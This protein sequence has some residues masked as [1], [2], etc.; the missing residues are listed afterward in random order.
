M[1]GPLGVDAVVV[2]GALSVGCA[3]GDCV[4]SDA[5]EDVAT[6]VGASWARVKVVTESRAAVEEV[7]SFRAG[8]CVNWVGTET[9]LWLCAILEAAIAAGVPSRTVI[10]ILNATVW[11]R[12]EFMFCGLPSLLTCS[13]EGTLK[14]ITVKVLCA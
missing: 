9:A 1:V 2:A 13:S 4:E 10:A 6:G 3:L 14:L 5:P 12:F 8:L 7:D 11:R